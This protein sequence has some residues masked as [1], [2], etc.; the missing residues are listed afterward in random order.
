MPLENLIKEQKKKN[1]EAENGN[2]NGRYSQKTW[3]C[4]AQV[5]VKYFRQ[6]PQPLSPKLRSGLKESDDLPGQNKSAGA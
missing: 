2:E 6:M 4:C 3:N 1:K 5:P